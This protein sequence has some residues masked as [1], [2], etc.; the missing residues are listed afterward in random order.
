MKFEKIK[1]YK[2]LGDRIKKHLNVDYTIEMMN[3]SNHFHYHLIDTDG[4]ELGL[5]CYFRG[6]LSFSPF[7]SSCR[8]ATNNNGYISFFYA[9]S[10]KR[11]GDIFQRLPSLVDIF[12]DD[13]E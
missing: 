9:P 8:E 4:I 3:D 1:N 13:N 7:N 12:E 5:L 11:I 10:F 6:E 2:A